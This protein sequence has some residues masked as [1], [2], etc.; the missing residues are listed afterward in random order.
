MGGVLPV[1]RWLRPERLL[2]AG[3]LLVLVCVTAAG[4][5]LD[6]SASLVEGG[7]VRHYAG[8]GSRSLAGELPYR[9]FELEHPLGALPAFVLP[10]LGGGDPETFAARFGLLI[11]ALLVCI[12][13][14]GYLI[15]RALELPRWRQLAVPL[16]VAATPVLLGPR[17]GGA[18]SARK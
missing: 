6:P 15:A 12:A 8:V 2:A 5:R 10:A 7:D 18:E 17:R 11:A 9:D 14:F 3:A 13:G 4:W 16:L 1:D